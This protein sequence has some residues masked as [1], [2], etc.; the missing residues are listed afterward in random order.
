MKIKRKKR[1]KEPE[2]KTKS[3]SSKKVKNIDFWKQSLMM[4]EQMP[5]QMM[6]INGWNAD[7]LAE[8][9]A[10]LTQKITQ[11]QRGTTSRRKGSS[12]ENTIAKKFLDK[13]GIRL[14]RTPMSG[15]F[16]KSSD[17]ESIRGDLSCLDESITFRLHPE[18]KNQKTWNLRSWYKQAG[19]DCPPGKI[20]I[21]IYHDSQKIK[22]GK[23][24]HEAG[25]FVKIRLE[26]FLSIVD[27]EKVVVKKGKKK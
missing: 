17:N 22:D 26:D 24:I 14:V 5:E 6:T 23:R 10:D 12:Y 19:E 20:P 21:V 15:G 7:Q 4:L 18:C 1:E 8:E 9:I 3:R 25:D 16:Q 13:W 11:S 2:K 27:V